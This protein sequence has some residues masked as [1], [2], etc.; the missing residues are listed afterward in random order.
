M[1]CQMTFITFLETHNLQPSHT[2][3]NVEQM[4]KISTCMQDAKKKSHSYEH[5]SFPQQIYFFFLM[6]LCITKSVHF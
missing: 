1:N 4:L 5:D 3:H 2:K 6:R